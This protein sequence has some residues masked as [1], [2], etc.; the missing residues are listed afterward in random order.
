MSRLMRYT[1]ATVMSGQGGVRD[2]ASKLAGRED[3]GCR[4]DTRPCR[5]VLD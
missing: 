1:A 3:D 2:N 4:G 5:S